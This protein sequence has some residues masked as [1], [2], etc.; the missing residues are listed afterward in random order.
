MFNLDDRTN[1][2]NEDQKHGHKMAIYSRSS[3]QNINNWRF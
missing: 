1:K 3:F 2:N